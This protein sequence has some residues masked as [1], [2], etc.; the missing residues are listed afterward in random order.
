MC[1]PSVRISLLYTSSI[2]RAH[3]NVLY[4]KCYCYQYHQGLPTLATVDVCLHYYAEA[5]SVGTVYVVCTARADGRA[6]RE[7]WGAGA[8]RVASTCTPL[9]LRKTAPGDVHGHQNETLLTREPSASVPRL[10]VLG[11]S[12]CCLEPN[13][14]QHYRS[15][16][17]NRDHGQQVGNCLPSATNQTRA[18]RADDE[19]CMLINSALPRRLRTRAGRWHLILLQ[20][21]AT[22]GERTGIGVDRAR[23]VVPS[24]YYKS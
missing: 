11:S 22:G 14:S 18:S 16:R 8:R 15:G 4:T 7:G 20:L 1:L 24:T 12:T 5:C 19:G 3:R 21:G 23:W 9:R 2:Q 10:P 6:G 17:A 13:R